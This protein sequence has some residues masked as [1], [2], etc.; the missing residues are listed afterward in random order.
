LIEKEDFELDSKAALFFAE[1]S[2]E[3]CPLR[4]MLRNTGTCSETRGIGLDF[5]MESE[6]I[7]KVEKEG[8]GILSAYKEEILAV[9]VADI[10]SDVLHI[11]EKVKKLLDKPLE[12]YPLYLNHTNPLIKYLVSKRLEEGS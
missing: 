9:G 12:D 8:V 1:F 5:M 6:I 10:G 3:W 11:Y 4:D 2:A 7:N